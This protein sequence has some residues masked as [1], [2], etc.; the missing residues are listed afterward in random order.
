MLILQRIKDAS[1][2]DLPWL[3]ELK[4]NPENKFPH[5]VRRQISK[6][7]NKLL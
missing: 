1:R 6:F 5:I 4:S 7:E 3:Y 2:K